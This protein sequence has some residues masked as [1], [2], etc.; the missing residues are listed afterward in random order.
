MEKSK[1]EKLDVLPCFFSLLSVGKPSKEQQK[2]RPFRK[3]LTRRRQGIP[4]ITIH[5]LS[6][7]MLIVLVQYFVVQRDCFTIFLKIHVVS[8]PLTAFRC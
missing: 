6:V 8:N 3:N 2:R 5:N 1:M 4:K 7:Y